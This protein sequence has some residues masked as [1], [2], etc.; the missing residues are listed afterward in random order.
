MFVAG[1]KREKGREEKKR[2][3]EKRKGEKEKRGKEKWEKRLEYVANVPMKS[4]SCKKT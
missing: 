2:K 1:Q 3:R 4:Q